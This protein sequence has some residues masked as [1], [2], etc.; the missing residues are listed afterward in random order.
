MLTMY[1]HKTTTNESRSRLAC[2]GT[3][4]VLDNVLLVE[5]SLQQ[6]SNIGSGVWGIQNS[7][8]S[9]GHVGA[10][11]MLWSSSKSW[12][13]ATNFQE[14]LAKMADSCARGVFG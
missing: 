11:A 1:K 13:I 10:S 5:K 4:R 9:G 2:P 7:I 8:G 14:P 12:C 3:P 6:K